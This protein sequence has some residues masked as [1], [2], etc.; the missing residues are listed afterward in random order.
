MKYTTYLFDFDGT[1]VD[2]MPAFVSVMLRILDE[3]HIPYGSDIVKII[4]PL[5]YAGT[6]RYYISLGLDKSEETLRA[7]MNDYAMDEYLYHIPAKAHVIE[8]LH[9]L[10]E[11]GAGL[12]V[13]T[14]SPHSVLDPCLKRLG[15]YDIFDNVWSCDDFATT[16]ADPEIYRMAARRIGADVGEILF[17]DDNYNADK[18]A[19]E[20]GMKVCGVFDESSSE[21][22]EEIRAVSDH[23]I[24]DFSELLTL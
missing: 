16:K 23:Y 10:K 4:T 22:A 19:K 14:A 2:S 21:Y 9:K 6:A 8:V 24:N 13:L 11:E 7:M 18:T 5:G 12:N 1:L 17:L 20:T 3:H 15:I